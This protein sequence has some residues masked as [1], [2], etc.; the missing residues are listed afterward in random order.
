[1]AKIHKGDIGTKFKVK[2]VDDDTGLPIDTSSA[3]TKTIKFQLPDLSVVEKTADFST[4]GN[5]GYIEYITIADDL[6]QA[7]R[8][9]IQGFVIDSGFENSSEVSEFLVHKNLS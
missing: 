8:W 3:T 9:K 1:M 7:G 2:I 4:N 5:D 6:S